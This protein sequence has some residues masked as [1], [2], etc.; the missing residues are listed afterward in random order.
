MARIHFIVNP[1][2]PS[3]GLRWPYEEK[4]I[5]SMTR[6]FQVHITR[7]RLHSEI[8]TRTAM[9]A[10]AELIVCAG[11]DSTLSEIVNGL[12]RAGQGGGPVPKLALYAG[13]QQ[14]DTVKGLRMRKTFL[15][16]L[17][18]YLAGEAIEEKID[19]GEARFTGDY[20][21][22]VR[23]LFVNCAGFGFSSVIVDKLSRDY[24]IS[25]TKFNFFRSIISLAPLYRH[26]EVDIFVDGQKVYSNED[27]LLGL[28]HNGNYGAYGLLL[29]P[30][31]SF[32]DGILEYTII[33]KTFAY[34]YLLGIFPLFAGKLRTASF[35]KQA[36]CKEIKIVSEQTQKK[37]RIDFDGDCWGFLPAEFRVLEKA[38]TVVR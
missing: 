9:E 11:G 26:P 13:L 10:G 16:F 29:S 33:S 22:Q 8:L 15:E 32:S 28:I 35:V 34:K 3:I 14:G 23:R 18:A 4:M 25:R 30:R 27:V 20:G 24:R 38:I 12:Y 36:S 19:V 2:R 21:Q 6:D 17:T 1:L 7:G 5:E 31:S 37:V